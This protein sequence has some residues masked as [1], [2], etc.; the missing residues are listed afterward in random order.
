MSLVFPDHVISSYSDPR[1]EL[2][3]DAES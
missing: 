1:P 2:A 3:L